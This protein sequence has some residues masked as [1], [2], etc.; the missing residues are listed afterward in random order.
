[1]DLQ[2]GGEGNPL[3]D[4]PGGKRIWLKR[5]QALAYVLFFA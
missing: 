3:L 2:D 5:S 4:R 1:M